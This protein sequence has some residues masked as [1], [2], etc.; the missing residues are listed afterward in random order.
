MENG[1]VSEA[2]VL[3]AGTLKDN[4]WWSSFQECVAETACIF[5]EKY[6]TCI[7]DNN[8][9]EGERDYFTSRQRQSRDFR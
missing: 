6:N 3:P 5:L 9:S 2:V 1:L 4:I 7:S 8:K